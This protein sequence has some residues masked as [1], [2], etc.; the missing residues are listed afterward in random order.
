MILIYSF[1][2]YYLNYYFLIIG[3][4]VGFGGFVF[5]CL[6]FGFDGFFRWVFRGF[7]WWFSLVFVVVKLAGFWVWIFDA[8]G[9]CNFG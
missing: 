9:V 5:L 2:L 6:A 3:L 4:V 1:I 7:V 8:F